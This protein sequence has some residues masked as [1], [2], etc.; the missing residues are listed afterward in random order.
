MFDDRMWSSTPRFYWEPW[1]FFKKKYQ[2]R[3]GTDNIDEI[4]TLWTILRRH[5]KSGFSLTNLRLS[6]ITINSSPLSQEIFQN[7]TKEQK[8]LYVHQ[9]MYC[10]FTNLGY[11]SWIKAVKSSNNITDALS[12]VYGNNSEIGTISESYRV[13][14]ACST[15]DSGVVGHGHYLAA[16]L[17]G[18]IYGESIV[19]EIIE[20]FNKENINWALYDITDLVQNWS[21]YKEFPI[22]WITGLFEIDEKDRKALVKPQL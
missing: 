7:F 8:I 12:N 9:I 11:A 21:E 15:R 20:R 4:R 17:L 6:H 22:S 2:K 14:I 10:D 1:Y 13:F 16:I 3:Y 19:K 5:L 18:K